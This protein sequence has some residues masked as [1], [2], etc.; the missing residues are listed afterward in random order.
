MSKICFRIC[1]VLCVLFALTFVL[2]YSYLNNMGLDEEN[3]NGEE[4]IQTFY[5]IAWPG[6]GSFIVGFLARY[7]KDFSEPFEHY[8]LGGSFFDRPWKPKVKSNWNKIGFWYIDNHPRNVIKQLWIGI[9]SWLPV[10]F[11]GVL[12]ILLKVK[13][14][15]LKAKGTRL[16][17][18]GKDQ[19]AWRK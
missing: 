18:E 16:L 3:K 10:V 4:I 6:N 17:A 13:G 12:A 2:S 11:F 15:R 19:R 14:T 7:K 8:D 1:I 5:R 9:P